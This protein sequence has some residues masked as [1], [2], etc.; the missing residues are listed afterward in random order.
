MATP[1]NRRPLGTRQHLQ[2]LIGNS[3]QK[4]RTPSAS[5]K[6]A[7]SPE[8]TGDALASQT[9]TK[10]VRATLAEPITTTLPDE[11]RKDKEQRRQTREAVKNEFRVKYTRAFPSWVFYFD[12]DQLDP[13]TAALRSSLASRVTQLGAVCLYN[14]SLLDDN[15]LRSNSVLKTF[16]QTRLPIWS[17]I[18]QYLLKIPTQTRRMLANY[19]ARSRVR[20]FRCLRVQ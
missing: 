9:S 14:L 12:L 10:R 7:R 2:Q 8:P 16:F 20:G 19:V 11:E 13:D 5:V 3:P 1:L 18:K 4:S 17:P 15:G 6:R